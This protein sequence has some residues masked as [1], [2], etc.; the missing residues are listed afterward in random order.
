M[1]FSKRAKN[2]KLKKFGR[3]TVIERHHQNTSAGKARWKCA[4]VCGSYKVVISDSLL[5]GRTVS[6]GCYRDEILA[7]QQKLH[8]GHS[9]RGLTTST[10]RIWADMLKRCTNS[11]HWAW[12]YYGGRGIKVCRRW[13]DFRN[14]LIDMGTRP[15]NLTL[16]RINNDKGYHR[17]NCRWATRTIQAR[18][19]R[20]FSV[21]KNRRKM[22]GDKKSRVIGG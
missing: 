22:V 14:F 16:D 8:H 6:C 5:S 19:R 12:K 15:K 3:L 1:K 4:C 9:R 11:K 21:S 20:A 2:L 17:E 13:F 18:N 10:Y 7:E